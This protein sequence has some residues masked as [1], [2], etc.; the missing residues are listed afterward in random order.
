MPDPHTVVFRLKRPQPSL[1]LMLASGYSP[2]YP[3]HVP[4]AELR[5]RCVGTG[6]FRF[7]QY[8]PRPGDRARAEP[9]LLR[10][11]PAL[12]RR[13]PLHDHRRARHAPRRAPDRP[14]RRLRAARDDEDHGGDGEEGRAVARDH[15]GRAE[16]QRQRGPQPQAAALRQP[17]GAPRHQLRHGPPRLRPGGAPRRRRRGRLDDAEAV[18]DLGAARPGPRPCPATGAP[19][20]DKA[21]AERLLAAAGYGPGKP[22]HVEM[23]TR[24]ISIYL[25]VASFVVDQLRQVGVESTLK[26]MD[27]AAW[28]P[29]LARR[30]Y[31]I[32]ANLTAGGFDDPDAYFVE[33]YKCG[34]SRNYT[35]YCSEETDRLIDLQS[36]EL[37]RGQAPQDRLGDPAQARGRRGPA[38]ARLA[39]GVLRAVAPR[40]EP[41]PAQLAVQLRRACRRCGWTSDGSGPDDSVTARLD[42]RATRSDSS[43]KGTRGTDDLS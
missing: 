38:D 26:Q 27:T 40:E 10:A 42:T 7:K 2:V 39:Q 37:D 28:F 34:S 29:A 17:G 21:E 19:A 20:Q 16:R 31:Q 24:S 36:Q 23:V 30:D 14:P 6:P 41:R 11:G 12:P 3:A 1:L 4:L 8:V 25:D 9:R 13:H 43:G 35:D 18:R 33:N 5:Q 32:G 22:L 15:R